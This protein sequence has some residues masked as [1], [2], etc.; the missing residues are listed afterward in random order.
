MLDRIIESAKQGHDSIS[1]ARK[2]Y[3]LFPTH[4]FTAD[5]DRQFDLYQAIANFFDVPMYS[6]QIV[7]SGKTGVSL[8]HGNSYD[9]G[10]SDLDVAVIDQLLFTKY[11]E[12]SFV[13]SEGFR[14]KDL[15]PTLKGKSTIDDFRSYL[16]KGVFRPDLMPNCEKRVEWRAFF[17]S[18]TKEYQD[19]C[20]K[21]SAGI[22]ATS[23]YF[24]WKQK[25]AI[26][27][28]LA[29]KGVL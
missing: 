28:F 22:Y 5:P 4:A 8:I 14:R 7:G 9:P 15:F 23:T 27:R 13:V 26:E 16:T 6:I 11:A 29:D 25:M 2:V 10:S 12:L 21:V 20:A 17:D 24:E 19:V 1:I 3:F 18:L